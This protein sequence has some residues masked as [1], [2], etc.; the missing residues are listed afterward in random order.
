VRVVIDTNVFV[1][2]FFGGKPRLIIDH[3]KVQKIT[4]CLSEAILEEYLDVLARIG[5][6]GEPEF[7]ELKALFKSGFNLVFA[8][9]TPQLTIVGLDPGDRKFIECAVAL[10]AERIIT[11]DKSFLEVANYQGI[12]IVSPAQFI[13]DS[14]P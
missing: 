12:R 3:W 11:A 14:A 9:K 2:S 10:N 5:L 13:K 8:A 4:L 7:E 6:A 1:S